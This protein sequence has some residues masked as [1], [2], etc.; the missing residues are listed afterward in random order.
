[1]L[2]NKKESMQPHFRLTGETHLFTFL[3]VH[4]TEAEFSESPVIHECNKAHILLADAEAAKFS[5]CKHHFPTTRYH[6]SML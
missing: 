1:M 2:V 3:K 6:T 4:V 5:G